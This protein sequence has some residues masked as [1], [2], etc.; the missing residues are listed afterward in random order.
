MEMDK[1][2][3]Q[4]YV[5]SCKVWP[6]ASHGRIYLASPDRY[7]TVLDEKTGNVVWR[8]NDPENRVRESIGISEDAIP[9]MP[10]RW[11]EKFSPLTPR[12]PSGR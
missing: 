12:F 2:A 1:R 8:Y 9:C 11:T 3:N 7:M 5:F 10:R 6:V 4:S